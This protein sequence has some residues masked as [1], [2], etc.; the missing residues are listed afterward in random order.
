MGKFENFTLNFWH[1]FLIMILL[2]AE[3]HE[4]E[5]LQQHSLLLVLLFL[6]G[7]NA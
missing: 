6:R 7:K 5:F 1:I 3:N 4:S 2:A